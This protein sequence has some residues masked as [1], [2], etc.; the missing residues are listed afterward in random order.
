L[1]NSGVPVSA[2][3]STE[4]TARG[5]RHPL[6]PARSIRGVVFDLDGTLYR[7]RPVRVCM[8]V[9]LAALPLARPAETFARL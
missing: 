8:A 7:Q 5:L 9:E 4:R 1:D 6:D 2:A 3:A